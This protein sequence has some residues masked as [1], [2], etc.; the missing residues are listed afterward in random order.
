MTR[1]AAAGVSAAAVIA[2]LGAGLLPGTA[3]AAGSAPV[4]QDPADAVQVSTEHNL[5]GPLTE[6]VEAEQKAATEQLLAGTAKIEQHGGG[7][8]IKL[9]KD[10]YVEL[11]RERTDK[12]FTIL[13]DFSDQ[14]DNTT[15]TPDGKV[16]FGGTPGPVHNQIEKPDAATNNSTLWQADYNQQHYQDM[17]FSKTQDS[18]KT[19]YEK[20]SSGR[21]TVDGQV[22]DWV[23]VPWNEARYGSDYC[24]QH[25]CNNAQDLIRDGI[26]AWVADQKAKGQTDAQIKAV[27][28]QYDQWDRYDYNHNGNFNEPDGYIDHFQIVHAGEDQSA[29]GGKQGTDAL[30][31]HRSYVYGTQRGSTGPANNLLGGTPVGD[32]GIWIGDYTMQPENGGLGVFAHEYGHDL[33]LPDL[34][35]TSGSGIDNS[36]G[37][38]SLMSSGSWL[39]EGKNSI[40][41]MPNDLDVWSKLKLGWLKFDKAKAGTESTHHIGPVEYN[42]KLPQALV[43]DLPKKTVTTV[44][45]T[46]FAGANEWWSGSADDL[47]VTMT[48]DVD[49]TGKTS[50]SLK[51]KAWYDLEQDFDYAYGEVSTDGGATWKTL[52]GTFNGTALPHNA[53]DKASLSGNSGDKWG[54]LVFP[55]DAYAGKAVKVRFHNTTDGGLHLKGLA[56]D[57]I[58]ITADGAT[59]FTDGAE[60]GDNGWAAKGFSRIA[61]KFS[62]EYANYYIAENRQYISYDRTLKTGP[63]NFGFG[64]AKPNWVEHYPYQAGLLI[65]YWDESQTDNN[66]TNHPGEGLILPIDSHPTPIKWADGTL[67]RPRIQGY[68]STFGSRKTD[69]LTLHKAGV[70]TVVPR[71]KGVDEFSDLKSYWSEDNKYSSVKVPKTGTSIEVEN[72]SSNY[73]ETWI[74]VRPVDN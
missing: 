33:G 57:E 43:V 15:K 47:D 44:I 48:R 31:A 34:Y 30:W 24:G 27:I 59:V 42:S 55:L 2:A 6:K 29:G 5:P 21:Y 8:S 62:N 26:N 71:A 69:A 73:L 40:G 53:A 68:D 38:W 23:K 65:W 32:T 1:K 70:E 37:F 14:V 3:Y 19:F 60:N 28:S 12:I 67:M 25:V 41:D 18:L 66:V 22:T 49:L 54:D 11:A 17:Y 4:P 72:E 36:V 51:A 20:Q 16:K 45:N 64:T 35:D 52:E 9:G 74:R 13:V 61:G 10:K 7:S 56:L 46:P 50:G 63:Y 39:G 58:S